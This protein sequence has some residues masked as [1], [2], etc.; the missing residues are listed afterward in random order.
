MFMARTTYDRYLAVSLVPNADYNFFFK[1]NS[2][3][4]LAIRV[5]KHLVSGLVL[6]IDRSSVTS[7]TLM[8]DYVFSTIIGNIDK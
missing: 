6:P 2:G 4:N 7:L 1:K 8:F 3:A 5:S